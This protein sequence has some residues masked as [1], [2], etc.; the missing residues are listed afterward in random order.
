MSIEIRG[1]NLVPA[2]ILFLLIYFV[3]GTIRG[4]YRYRMIEKYQYDYYDNHPLNLIGRLIHNLFYGIFALKALF[5]S[6]FLT[7]MILI[8]ANL[9]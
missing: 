9:L 2:T 1:F 4:I 5:I 8:A 7:I 6:A 3:V